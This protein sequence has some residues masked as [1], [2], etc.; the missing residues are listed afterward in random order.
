[1]G[2]LQ[3]KIGLATILSK[4]SFELVDKKLIENEIEFDPKQFI[5]TSKSPALIKVS[6][7]T[8]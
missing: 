4:F 6:K 8:N 5:L 1:M 2:K 3:V 7:R